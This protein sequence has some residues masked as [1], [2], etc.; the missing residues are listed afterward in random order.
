[1]SQII[2]EHLIE[3][4][5]QAA[6]YNRHDLAPPTVVL[7]TDGE[8]LWAP[9]IALI[10]EAMPELLVL[11][12]EVQGEDAGP[13]T[14]VR[15][16][17]ARRPWATTPV[18]YLPGV[19]RQAFRGAAGFPEAARHLFA[20]Q[21]Q[22]QF[23][24]Q[25]NHKDWTPSAFL[26]SDEG[27]LGLDLARDRATLEAV[28][29]Q[30]AYVLRASREALAG[31]RLE[32][33][34][35]HG[36]A[37]GDSVGLMLEWMGT[38]PG[39]TPA[40]PWKAFTALAK[41]TFKLDPEKDGVI[42]AVERLLA[43]GGEWDQV[44]QRWCQA[45]RAFPGV[46]KALDLVQPKDLFDEAN[47]RYPATNRKREDDL[48]KALHGLAKMHKSKALEHI[49]SL[50]TEHDP[51]AKSVWADLNE[52]PLAR[53]MEHLKALADGIATG[54][55]G[56][57]WAAL[58]EA[59][60]QRGGA[61]DSAAWRAYD[62]VRDPGDV[63]AVTN[64]LRAVY[65]PWVEG[66]AEQVQGWD[67]SAYPGRTSPHLTPTPGTVLVF[68]DGLR[69][70]LGLELRR[71]LTAQGLEVRLDTRW[72][73]LPTVTAT[74]KPA[75]SPLADRLVGDTLPD[76]FEPQVAETGKPLT[77]QSFRKLLA[78][79]G[80]SWLEPGATG[81]PEG[82]AW[83]EV[84]TFDHDG[85]AQGERLAWRLADEL[86][87]IVWR[88]RALLQA[89]WSQAVLVTDHGWL[90]MPGG[91]PKLDLPG[92]LTQSRWPRCAVAAPGAQHGFPQAHWFW[93]GGH[94]VVLAP[95]V[96]S[97]KAGVEY[98]HGGL[99]V[100][101]ALVPVLTVRAPQGSAEPVAILSAEWKGLRLRVA[102]QGAYAGT[103]LDIRTKAAAAGTSVL[104]PGQPLKA[105]GAD[106]QASLVVENDA[107]EGTSAVL[108]VVRDGQVVA[109]QPVTIGGD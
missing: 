66:L 73:A 54:G 80:W 84:G 52:A 55:L 65:L 89:G 34:D 86:N 27:G 64:A 63:E 91:L 103:L 109:K 5:R 8:R 19:A 69:C 107:L 58:A 104:R 44:W 56:H 82:A 7:W 4:L 70:D 10:R 43:G 12:P 94:A 90:W 15:Y 105:P 28:S 92:H 97:F 39:A 20:L 102:L 24:T 29:D 106:G 45:P 42:T 62:A 51:R 1:M 81:D 71:L 18:L 16:Q 3:R 108:V 78:A 57:N 22:G 72:S 77:S 88:V 83:T 14:W 23:W 49:Q 31:R 59:Y 53:A 25:V 40:P 74:A 96:G 33:S 68:V 93:G 11:A 38:D 99:S 41:S 37:A 67:L 87:A 32:A 47:D 79:C 95:G 17:L 100:Q 2:L 9:V 85:H 50:A 13:S 26:A 98:S 46:R 48:R 75:W 101:E 36:L 61:I 30:L 76:G 60:V 35:F 21:F 6:I